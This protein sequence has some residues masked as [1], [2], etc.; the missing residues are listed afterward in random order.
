MNSIYINFYIGLGITLLAIVVSIFRWK[1]LDLMAKIFSAGMAWYFFTYLVAEGGLL[2]KNISRNYWTFYLFIR[3]IQP[4]IEYS[5]CVLFFYYAIPELRRRKITTYLLP[6]G[7]AIW[8]ACAIIFWNT[9]NFNVYFGPFTNLVVIVLSIIS[10]N[11]LLSNY[12]LSDAIKLPVFRFTFLMLFFYGCSIFFFI[13]YPFLL[14]NRQAELFAVYIMFRI[15]DI[16]YVG[17]GITYFFYPK[18]ALQIE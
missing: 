12:Q 8:T 14:Q 4:I 10:I 16:F 3:N 11:I 18:K 6:T 15:Y 5:L 2:Y 9:E 1:S 17:A 13:S 7:W